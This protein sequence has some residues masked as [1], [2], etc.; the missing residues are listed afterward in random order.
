MTE[1]TETVTP[2]DRVALQLEALVL[3]RLEADELILPVL[4][5]Q[6]TKCMDLVRRPDYTVNKVAEILET[7]PILAARIL[8]VVNSAAQGARQ[9]ITNLQSAVARLGSRGVYSAVVEATAAS[10]FESRDARIAQATKGLWQH[11]VAVAVASRD[12]AI[13]AN[14]GDPED[15]YLAG[16]LHDVGKPVLAVLMLDAEKQI[17]ARSTRAWLDSAEWLRA[18]ARSHRKVG[19]SLATR[20]QLPENIVRGIAESGDYDPADRRSVANVVRFAN[21]VAKD[22]GFYVGHMDKE[23]VNALIMIGRS[24]LELDDGAIKRISAGLVQKMQ[25]TP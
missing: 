25:A 20:W 13:L 17:T 8:R 19:V 16:L 24:L 9:P 5:S 3:R 21:A 4:S 7:D 12:L 11:S 15:C 23:E 10:V 6:A 18:I 14:I 1:T 22:Q 2:G